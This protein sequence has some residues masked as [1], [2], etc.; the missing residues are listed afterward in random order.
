MPYRYRILSLLFLLSIITYLDRVCISVAG[1]RMQDE[2]SISPEQWGWIV[3]AFTI[4]YAAF[5]IPAGVWGDKYGP[6]NILTRIVL[7]WSAFTAMTGAATS[8]NVLLATRF[9]FGAGEAGAY[10][11]I[12][13][14]VSRWFPTQERAR[15][16]G[17]TWMASR[18]GGAL[19]PILVVPIQQLYGW[20]ATFFIFGAVGLVWCAWWWLYARDNPRDKAGISQ[21]ELEHIGAPKVAAAHVSLPW[22]QVI[23]SRN[24]QTILI[25]YHTYCWGSYFYLSWLH[26]Y[27]QRGRGF[28]ENEMKLWSTLPFLFGACGNLI[29]GITSDWLCKKYGLKIGRR[30]IGAAG[31]ALSGVFMLLTSQVESKE[32]AVVFLALGYGSMDCMLPVSWAVCMDVGKKYAGAVSGSMNMA[33]QLGSFLSS[34]LFGYMVG[35]FGGDYN[36]ALIPL[37]SMLLVSAALF[38][39]IDPTEQLVEEKAETPSP[40]PVAA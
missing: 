9:F 12:S 17:I 28:T 19:S 24:F 35:W 40:E 3:G 30:S 1:K 18:L 16:V 8:F 6:R 31:L 34:V 27:L 33:G 2:M 7:W 39:R 23:K 15:A 4:S 14:S 25:M 10:P 13:A 29:G 20:R 22:S 37:A 32:W 11:N 36:K 26:T 38:L 5:E 21:A